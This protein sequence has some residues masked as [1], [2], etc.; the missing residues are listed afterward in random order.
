ML[1]TTAQMPSRAAHPSVR[2][3]SYLTTLTW[4]F[5]LFNSLRTLSY[6]PTMWAIWESGDSTQHSLWTWFVWVGANLTMAAWLYEQNHQRLNKAV[7]VNLG[8]TV[9]CALTG[10]LILAH[11]DGLF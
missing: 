2:Q 6:L 7:I 8:N 5:T 9:M 4:A 10:A 3:S 1:T 11:R